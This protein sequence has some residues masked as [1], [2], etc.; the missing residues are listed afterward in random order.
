MIAWLNGGLLDLNTS[1]TYFVA[2]SASISDQPTF[3]KLNVHSEECHVLGY[4]QDCTH[5]E[6]REGVKYLGVVVDQHLKWDKHVSSLCGKIR[7]LF[8]KYYLLREILN[9]KLLLLLYAALVESILRYCIVVW[10]GAYKNSVH[11]LEVTQ[12]TVLKI[13]FNK[14]RL[15]PTNELYECHRLMNLRNLY[16]LCSLLFLFKVEYIFP[17]LAH[18]YSTRCNISKNLIM[19]LY[20]KNINQR[21]LLFLLPKMYNLLPTEL[22]DCMKD[23]KVYKRRLKTFILDNPSFLKKLF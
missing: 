5:I 3:D 9:R 14:P 7:M 1:K 10:G 22:R 17:I 19:P 18:G 4:C 20:H 12:N 16:C 13:L 6:K 8:H 15:F 2:F 11:S 21:F 23:R